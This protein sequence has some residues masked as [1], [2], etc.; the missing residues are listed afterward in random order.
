MDTNT[1]PRIPQTDGW[2]GQLPDGSW[3]LVRRYADGTFT[4]TTRPDDGRW[5]IEVPLDHEAVR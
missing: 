4:G 5:G 1:T 2:V 3:V